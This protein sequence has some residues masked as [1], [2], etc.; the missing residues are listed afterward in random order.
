MLGERLSTK[1]HSWMMRLPLLVTEPFKVAE[2]SETVVAVCVCT[3]GADKVLLFL[4]ISKKLLAD[5]FMVE[6]PLLPNE[7]EQSNTSMAMAL[8]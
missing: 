7:D 5:D 3:V 8:L 1:P 6:K 4:N 2:I